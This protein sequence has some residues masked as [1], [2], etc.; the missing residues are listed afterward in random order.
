MDSVLHQH[1][2]YLS[3]AQQHAIISQILTSEGISEVV[4]TIRGLLF[5]EVP[6]SALLKLSGLETAALEDK[7]LTC[8]QAIFLYDYLSKKTSDVDLIRTGQLLKGT[9][10]DRIHKMDDKFLI[11]NFP[12]F[13]RNFHLLSPFQ[14]NCLA[15]RFWDILDSPNSTIPSVLMLA[16]P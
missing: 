8:S 13:K 7:H 14:M 2:T 9:T 10:C 12:F 6:L 15:W 1:A 16:L 11:E 3:P 5:S 4:R